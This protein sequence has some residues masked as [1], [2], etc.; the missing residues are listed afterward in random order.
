MLLDLEYGM[1]FC[2]AIR[3]LA[4]RCVHLG[5]TYRDSGMSVGS[6]KR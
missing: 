2:V 5:N 6:I 3:F 1:P 4:S